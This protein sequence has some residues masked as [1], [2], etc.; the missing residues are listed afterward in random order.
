MCCFV[1]GSFKIEPIPEILKQAATDPHFTL[2]ICIWAVAAWNNL[3]VRLYQAATHT[4]NWNPS[5]NTSCY[6]E[7][8]NNC[9]EW[10]K[11]ERLP[12]TK[13]GMRTDY[14]VS[15]SRPGILFQA[16][17]LSSWYAYGLRITGTDK[18]MPAHHPKNRRTVPKT[19]ETPEYAW[20]SC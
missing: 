14:P 17:C 9:R 7:H 12:G 11:L 5:Q 16:V 10:T 3:T 15:S 13:N 1:R 18:P 2:E 19:Q 20:L 6:C 8:K 4:Y